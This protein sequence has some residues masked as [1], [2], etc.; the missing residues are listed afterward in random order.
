LYK[1]VFYT[2]LFRYTKYSTLINRTMKKQL[3]KFHARLQ[4]FGF[5]G[6]KFIKAL[7][8]EDY[9]WFRNDYNKFIQQKGNDQTFQ[10]IILNPILTDKK[11]P[12]GTMKGHYFHQD[13]YVAR[14]IHSAN[15][16]K[17]VDIGSRTDGFVAHV[18]SYREIELIDIRDIKSTV[19]NIKFKQVDLMQDLP[20]EFMGYCDS[21][22]SLHA[23]EHFG[24]G[25]YGDPIDYLGYLKAIKNISNML[26][27]NGCF[28]FSVPIGP[29]RIEFNAHRV[30]SM[31]Y[32]LDVLQK[33][34]NLISFSYVDDQGEFHEN[35][36]LNNAL[37]LGNLGCELGCGIFSL[38]KKTKES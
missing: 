1:S 8:N 26:T 4:H 3:K 5:D 18:A 19:Y 15:P 6:M 10:K 30:F 2:I 38:V 34:F 23:I 13:L 24:L 29:Q 12:G 37:I 28:Y 33:D 21:M 7:K 11:E 32:I 36:Q 31:K 20:P 14:M 35:I 17:H 22:S 25:R 27:E 9:I 16:S